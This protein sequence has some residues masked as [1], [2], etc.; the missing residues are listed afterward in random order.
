MGDFYESL[1]NLEVSKTNNKNDL[2]V[3]QRK[4]NYPKQ[5]IVKYAM[6]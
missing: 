1:Q 5:A 2:I 6:M 3:M 4:I